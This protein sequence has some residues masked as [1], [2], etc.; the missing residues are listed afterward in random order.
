M[1]AGL[2]A[3]SSSPQ[4]YTLAPKAGVPVAGSG[5]SV[6][7]VRTPVVPAR[8]DRDTIVQESKGYR[9][10]LASGNSWSE[11]LPDML[12]HTLAADI[13]QRMPMS[14]VIAQNDAVTTT[15]TAYVEVTIRN[16]ESDSS[17]YPIIIAALSAHS[18]ASG[19]N[20]VVSTEPFVWRSSQYVGDNS[21]KLVAA[22]S[23]GVSVLADHAVAKLNSLPRF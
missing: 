19:S 18:A 2:S 10:E 14:T 23:D 3:C 6:V 21:D 12:G 7:E 5:S 9:T 8:L 4:L 15:P 20:A 13:G 16:F 11:A 22:L 17:G 1:A